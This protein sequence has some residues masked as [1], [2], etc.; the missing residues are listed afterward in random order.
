MEKGP[1]SQ[2]VKDACKKND[3]AICFFLLLAGYLLFLS[4]K[5]QAAEVVA[6]EDLGP[7]AIRELIVKDFPVLVVYDAHGKDLYE[8]EIAKY[9]TLER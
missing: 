2:S 4:D 8:Q 9:R 3:T 7:E 6:Y 1:R 5:I